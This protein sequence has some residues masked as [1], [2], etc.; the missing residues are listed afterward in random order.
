MGDSLFPSVKV[1]SAAAAFLQALDG[2]CYLVDARGRV[3]G[4]GGNAWDDFARTGGAPQ[5]ADGF[6]LGR[7]LFRAIA[8]APVR[9]AYRRIHEGV[10]SERTRHVD[11][12]YRCDAPD[13]R[14]T[15]RMAVSRLCLPGAAP[16]LLYQSQILA[17]VNRPWVSLFEP[18]RIIERIRQ[19][20]GVPIVRMC[21]FCQRVA[22]P[23]EVCGAWLEAEDYYR[24]G[25][26]GDVRVSHGVCPACE[27]RLEA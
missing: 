5:I 9:A 23:K 2:V 12:E 22:W 27:G 25:G 6:I 14:R 11:F 1:R 24:A 7:S 19:D 15:M 13:V 21:S 20:H 3:R 18:E 16:G 10:L 26:P 8:G 4:V 17:A